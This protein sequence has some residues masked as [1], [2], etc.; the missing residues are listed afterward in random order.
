MIDA[1]F[2]H[3]QHRATGQ[4][5]IRL[6]ASGKG[7][8]ETSIQ[9]APDAGCN[10]VSFE[11][12]GTEYIHAAPSESLLHILGT[13]IL[14]PMPNRVRN[15]A[16]RY[17]GLTLR[18]APNMGDHFIH[19]LVHR[20][21]WTVDEPVVSHRGVSLRTAIEFAPA[22]P[23]Y[24][25]FP[26]RNTLE[27]TYTLQP[28]TVRYDWTVRN[29]DAEQDLPFGLAIHP[30]FRVIGPRESVRLQV[31]AQKRME[32]IGLIP[33]G[34]LIDL[35][36]PYDLRRP[37]SLSGLDLDDVYWGMAQNSPAV[38]Y[39]DAIGQQLTLAASDFFTHCVVYTPAGRP[40]FCVEN[41]SCSTDAHNLHTQGHREA[42]HLA[43]LAPGEALSAW[44]AFSARDQS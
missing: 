5:T 6:T 15:G 18:F 31:P 9:I 24:E 13:P 30:Y 40:Y 3:D 8:P 37:A 26:I 25:A 14:Y 35:D 16:L 28:G 20:A 34:R 38:I 32:A 39:Y 44:I 11:V 41:Q 29:T 1:G 23:L 43:V 12:D 2:S 19:G 4:R 42:A 36:P 17:G 27:L 10:L 7:S 33:T 21:Q 22:T